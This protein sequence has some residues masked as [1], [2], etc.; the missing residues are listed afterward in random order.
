MQYK[1]GVIG[2]FGFGRDLLNGQT[3][4][5]KTLVSA[6]SEAV[7][8][9]EI[10]LVD[11]YGGIKALLRLPVQCFRASKQCRNLIMLPARKGIRVIAPLLVLYQLLFHRTLHYVVIG[12][13]LNDL[14]KGKPVLTWCLKRFDWIYAET[15]SMKGKLEAAGFRN[16]VLMPN[17]KLLPILEEEDSSER[18]GLPCR[19]CTFS[20]VL[21][22]KGIETAVKAVMAANGQLNRDAYSLDIY[23]Q[24]DTRQIQWFEDLKTTFP[25]YIRY[26]GEVPFDQSV[27][28]LKGYDALLFPT[29]YYTEGVPGTIIDAYAAG[30]PVIA[31]RWENYGDIVDAQ[32]GIGFPFGHPQAL[33]SVLVDLNADSGQLK[34]RRRA[35]LEKAREFLPEAVIP[36]LLSRLD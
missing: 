23:G 25:D 8:G 21:K 16:V 22:E 30:I 32:T 6:L 24:V 15:G 13:W 17:F 10:L 12:S 1:V 31:S 14:L 36:T 35:C 5:T 11:T 20:R 19:L 9:E 34:K 33:T 3:I 2:R 27:S 7:G 18:I 26:C 29:Q 4:K 28:V